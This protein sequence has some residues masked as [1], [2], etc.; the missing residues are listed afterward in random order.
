MV[1]GCIVIFISFL[2]L[3]SYNSHIA[4]K[5]FLEKHTGW[6]ISASQSKNYGLFQ[7]ETYLETL[8]T[9]KEPTHYDG[10][11]DMKKKKASL[12]KYVGP[13]AIPSDGF[14]YIIV[15]DQNISWFSEMWLFKR[16]RFYHNMPIFSTKE[17]KKMAESVDPI[18]IKELYFI[19]ATEFTKQTSSKLFSDYPNLFEKKLQENALE[20]LYINRIDGNPA[21]AIYHLV[22]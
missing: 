17:F 22:F 13:T 7:L 9:K 15:Y 21:F 18:A 8:F 19:K 3:F 1:K 11:T 5:P 16:Q 4:T 14:S 20:P 6:S 10:Y 2:F 12:K